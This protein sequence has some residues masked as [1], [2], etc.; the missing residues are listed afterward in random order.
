MT[1]SRVYRS[2]NA[3]GYLFGSNWTSSLDPYRVVRSTQA[4]M[5]T[6]SGCFTRSAT[7]YFPDG[8]KYKY[9]LLPLSP[10]EYQAQ[11]AAAM[12]TM[13]GG[14]SGSGWSLE[15][16]KR[17]YQ[18]NSLG[19]QTSVTEASGSVLN[20]TYTAGYLT[21][22]SNQN[23]RAFNF[24]WTGGKVTSVLDPAGNAWTYGYT[25]NMLTSVTSPA[26]A[27]VTADIRT[28]HYETA[29]PTLL[30]GV[31]INT[32]R[33]STYTYHPDKRVAQSGL[34]GVGARDTFTYVT[35]ATTV[36]NAAGQAT[37]YTFTGTADSLKVS[38]VSRLGNDTCAAATAQTFYD[39]NNHVDYTLDWNGVK[40]DYSY[41]AD[42][43]LLAVTTALGTPAA[44]TVTN[45]WTGI[46]VTEAQ[47]KGADGLAYAKVNYTYHAGGLAAGKLQSETWT[48]MKNGGPVRVTT[49]G[50][51]FSPTRTESVTKSLPGGASATGTATWDTLGNLVTMTNALGQQT[52][53]SNYNGLGLPGR[54]TDINGVITNYDYD[55]KGN[56]RSS[57]LLLPDG[58]VRTTHYTFNNNRQITD[59]SYASGHANRLRYDAAMRAES[60]GNGPGEFIQRDITTGTNTLVE[61]SRS[62]RKTATVTGGVPTALAA[63]QFIS[64]T[65][66]DALGRLRRQL[67][68]NG[69]VVTF[70]YDANGN[71]KTRTDVGRRVT[72]WS[73]DQ[74]N[75]LIWVKAPDGGETTYGYNPQGLLQFVRDP[76]GLQTDYT[77]NGFGDLLTLRSPDTGTTTYTYDS[78]GR[79]QTETRASGQVVT[80]TWDA[81]GRMVS[82]SSASLGT[83]SCV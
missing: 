72:Q 71:V 28:Y 64:T 48:D 51:T 7:V 77:Y 82:R 20:Y 26:S 16:G 4:C 34:T 39:A 42:G 76:R 62:G 60:A 5:N 12:G 14:L 30:T 69:Q 56:L 31:S 10:G 8:S 52:V 40:T 9:T 13:S 11:G 19:R 79:L 17:T 37:T 75:R 58:G 41:H 80:T 83:E 15:M 32:Q 55:V 61:T 21:R 22:V 70:T 49:Y 67:G 53:W 68:N 65:E 74:Q 18:F 50:Y 25:G 3:S 1:L 44:H 57:S 23:G 29:E 27:G 54:M 36:T 33:H 24:T 2:A 46:D 47:Y 6:E 78:A 81:L 43:R 66:S 63:G 59:V 38:T 45:T 73:Y 35:N